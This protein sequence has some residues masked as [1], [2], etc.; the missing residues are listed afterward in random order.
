MGN[1]CHGTV[2]QYVN[3]TRPQERKGPPVIPSCRYRVNRSWKLRPRLDLAFQDVQRA[4]I[5]AVTDPHESGRQ[6]AASRLKV[7]RAYADYRQMLNVE[8]PD[9][10]LYLSWLGE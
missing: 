1:F 2:N 7:T 9:I 4:E 10:G 6:K 3:G 5:M 8:K